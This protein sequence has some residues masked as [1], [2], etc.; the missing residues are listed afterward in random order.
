MQEKIELDLNEILK[1]MYKRKLLIGGVTIIIAILTVLINLFV[2]KPVYEAKVSM[3]VGQEDIMENIA[4]AYSSDTVVLSQK[5]LKTYSEIATSETVLKKTVKDLGLQYD[6]EEYELFK[7]K[8][9][10]TYKENTQILEISVQDSNPVRAQKIANK[11]SDNFIEEADEFL[12]L[13]EMK[14]LDKASVPKKAVKPNKTLN[15]IVAT[16]ITFI[17]ASTIILL[18]DLKQMKIVD[19][20]D[21]ERYLNL[22]V[23]GLIRNID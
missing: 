17:V 6:D 5:L 1:I 7:K 18:K 19:E 2:L 12:P 3:V 9:F 14:L 22:K 13:G 23:V 8:I 4:Y 10:V 15:V 16:S 20:K 11:L 21:V